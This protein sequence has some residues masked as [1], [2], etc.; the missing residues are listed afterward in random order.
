[1]ILWTH[2][3]EDDLSLLL[4]Q[5]SVNSRL[6]RCHNAL[7]F[8]LIILNI[9][10][11]RCYYCNVGTAKKGL[12]FILPASLHSDVYENIVWKRQGPHLFKASEFG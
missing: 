1:M 10:V 3:T 11:P 5:Y 6:T 2:K 9:K 7:V 8:C 12:K 4:V